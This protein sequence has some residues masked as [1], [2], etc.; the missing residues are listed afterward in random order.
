[1]KIAD[2]VMVTNEGLLL[3][4]SVES[5]EKREGLKCSYE[6]TIDLLLFSC[7]KEDTQDKFGLS[8]FQFFTWLKE[9]SIQS[10]KIRRDNQH[11][12]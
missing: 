7:D 8:D 6:W 3:V 9:L 5:R 12:L 10:A 2:P 4:R 11:R 1:M